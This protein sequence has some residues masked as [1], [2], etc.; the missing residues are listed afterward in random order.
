MGCSFCAVLGLWVGASLAHCIVPLY[1]CLCE[2]A[3]EEGLGS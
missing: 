2:F 1:P 3:W